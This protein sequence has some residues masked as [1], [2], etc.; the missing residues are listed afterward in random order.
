[1]LWQVCTLFNILTTVFNL[2][3]VYID[4]DERIPL[5]TRAVESDPELPYA[6]LLRYVLAIMYQQYMLN[7]IFC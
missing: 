3:M 1:M 2:S 4:H 6:P 5:F 7:L